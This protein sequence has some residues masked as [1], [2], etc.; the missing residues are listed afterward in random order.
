MR[1][2]KKTRFGSPASDNASEQREGK[3]PLPA[4]PPSRERGWNSGNGTPTPPCSEGEAGWGSAGRG[5]DAELRDAVLSRRLPV[6]DMTALR[7]AFTHKSL[8]P[9]MPL[10]SNERL[11]FLGD[12]VLGLV[13]GEY[14]WNTYPRRTEGE[15]AKARA[16][17][18]C[19]SALAAAA[20]RLDLPPLLRLGHSE[21]AMGGRER[22]GLA[23]DVFEALL[24]VIYREGGYD[25]A[26]A[27]LLEALAPEIAAV[28][29]VRDWRDAKTVLQE[30]RQAEHLSPPVYRVVAEQGRPHDKTFA[31]EVLLDDQVVGSGV[32]KSK[33]EAQ[34]AAAEAALAQIGT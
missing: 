4:P 31:I 5:S 3:E 26:R 7:Q 34:Q 2:T 12:A 18:V 21:E 20:R 27:F 19:K 17:I 24:A 6:Q 15:L 8:V 16:L 29:A 30:Q 23:A 9:D 28:A 14:L 32:G 11:E 13:I 25:A 22:S 1:Y 10:A 33:K